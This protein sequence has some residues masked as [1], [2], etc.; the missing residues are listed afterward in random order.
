MST[1]AYPKGAP[2][3]P[4]KCPRPRGRQRA[5]GRPDESENTDAWSRRSNTRFGPIPGWR[6]RGSATSVGS[7][8]SIPPTGT[9]SNAR[10]TDRPKAWLPWPTSRPRAGAD[11]VGHGSRRSGRRCSCR[12]CYARVCRSNEPISSRSPRVSPP[13]TRSAQLADVQ[14]GLKWPNDVVIDD[15]KLAG[16]L[17]ET[18]GAGAV[19][20]GMGCNVAPG[21]LPEE[22][23]DI[24]IRGTG[25]SRE[26]AGRLARAR[27]TRVSTPSTPWSPTR[28]C[29][30]QPSAGGCG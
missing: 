10:Q 28:P 29:D 27:T 24:A 21:A 16:I 22:L 8:A 19:V 9:C 12:C 14:A 30:R 15:R 20:V 23:A 25:G 18:D 5:T 13:S 4:A 3:G 26:S 6:A 2:A 1:A 11:W 7:T 17:A